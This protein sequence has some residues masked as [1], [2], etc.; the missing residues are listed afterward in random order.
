L[1]RQAG[2]NAQGGPAADM[3]PDIIKITAEIDD[4]VSLDKGV[5]WAI[6][7]P[8]IIPGN[9][10]NFIDRGGTGDRENNIGAGSGAGGVADLDRIVAGVARLQIVQDKH[11]IGRSGNVETIE[12]PLVTQRAGA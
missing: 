5:D 1:I 9:A 11:R 4:A 6:G 3:G 7:N 8:E 10:R 2:S 12:P